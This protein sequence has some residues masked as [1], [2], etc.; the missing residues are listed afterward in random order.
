M[1]DQIQSGMMAMMQVMAA[2][3]QVPQ[4]GSKKAQGAE[5]DFH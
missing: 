4:I 1:T 2:Q 3:S 5:D